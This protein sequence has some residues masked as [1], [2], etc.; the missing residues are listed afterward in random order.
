M[1]LALDR[2]QPHIPTIVMSKQLN[3]FPTFLGI[4]ETDFV[5]QK[6]K[7]WFRKDFKKISINLAFIYKRTAKCDMYVLTYYSY[8]GQQQNKFA[9]K[10]IVCT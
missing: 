4:L 3:I 6:I 10:E 5:V 8:V 2:V 1:C 9:Q 7:N